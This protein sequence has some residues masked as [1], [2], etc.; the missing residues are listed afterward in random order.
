MK[1]SLLLMIVLL[2]SASWVC[3][4]AAKPTD[5]QLTS[6]VKMMWEAFKNKDTKTFDTWLTEDVIDVG[7]MG[8][9]DKAGIKKMMMDFNVA[10]YSLTDFKVSWIDQ[11]AVIV[12]YKAFSKGSYQGKE[13]PPGTYLCTDIWVSQGDKWLG[14]FHQ[15]TPVMEMPAAAQQ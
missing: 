9:M 10:E 6:T 11:D 13:M 1:K 8:A 5:E 14:K 3:L 12:T 15:E 4:A 7:P 2:V